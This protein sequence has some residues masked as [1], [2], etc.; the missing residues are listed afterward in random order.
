MDRPLPGGN[1]KIGRRRSIEGERRRGR[2]LFRRVLLFPG[3][4]T[5]SVA[6]GRFFAIDHL[7]LL[8][9]RGADP[10]ATDED[11]KS[12][13]QYAIES[14]DIDYEDIIFLSS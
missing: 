13:V 9:S 10:H 5:Q 8:E 12:P 2:N 4:P 7:L 3:S 14:G 11:G 6:H 1:A